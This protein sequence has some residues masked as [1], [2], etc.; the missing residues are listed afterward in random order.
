MVTV[1]AARI[2]DIPDDTE[3]AAE[4]AAAE[5]ADVSVETKRVVEPMMEVAMA[6]PPEETVV[7]MAAESS[8]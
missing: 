5:E 4:E 3:A 2:D 1:E 7:R 6:L 8:E